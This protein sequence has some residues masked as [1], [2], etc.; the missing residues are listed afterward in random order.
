MVG[1]ERHRVTGGALYFGTLL[2]AWYLLAAAGDK[3]GSFQAASALFGSFLGQLVLF[4]YTF[5]LLLHALGG[6]RHAI[7]DAG[8]RLRSR[9]ARPSRP[10][11]GHHPPPLSRS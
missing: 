6:L 10:G 11:F 7:W 8:Y 3:P 5:A 9:A 2:L 4:G 1:L